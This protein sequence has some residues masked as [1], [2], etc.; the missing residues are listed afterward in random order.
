[1]AVLICAMLTRAVYHS[2]IHASA[3]TGVDRLRPFCGDRKSTSNIESIERIKMRVEI[4]DAV[5]HSIS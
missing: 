2:C 5:M 3:V 4:D 1:M